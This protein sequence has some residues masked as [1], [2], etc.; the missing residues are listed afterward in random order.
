MLYCSV[1]AFTLAKPLLLPLR[2]AGH[3]NPSG[4]YSGASL[5]SVV[6]LSLSCPGSCCAEAALPQQHQPQPG[7]GTDGP[8]LCHISSAISGNVDGVCFTTGNSCMLGEHRVLKDC[9]R[10]RE[11]KSGK[12]QCR[13]G[14]ISMFLKTVK[15]KTNLLMLPLFRLLLTCSPHHHTPS[16]TTQTPLKQK[17]CKHPACSNMLLEQIFSP[18]NSPLCK[19]CPTVLWMYLPLFSDC[20]FHPGRHTPEAGKGLALL[21]CS[22]QGLGVHLRGIKAHRLR[23]AA[24]AE[25]F[26]SLSSFTC[27]FVFHEL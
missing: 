3:T 4:G 2:A 27:P 23:I 10:K 11:K 16:R 12:S 22:Q 15:T 18:S 9:G 25:I 19:V 6:L 21:G 13:Y 5:M 26:P 1:T 24:P 7:A 14:L 8:V 20:W 17:L